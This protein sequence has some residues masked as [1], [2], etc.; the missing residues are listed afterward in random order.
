MAAGALGVAQR[1]LHEAAKYTLERKAFGKV[2][3]E[4]Q[5]VAFMLADMA[6]GIEAARLMTWRSAWEMDLGRRNSYYAS[7]AKTLASEI[8]NKAAAD[9]V[10]VCPVLSTLELP[11]SPLLSSLFSSLS[12]SSLLLSERHSHIA[13]HVLLVERSPIRTRSSGTCCSA[14][15]IYP[16]Y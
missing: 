4:H 16:I 9:A 7:I 5:A 15:L 10:Q 2:I 14:T 1:A 6:I 11:S 13:V 12:L 8:A 3:A